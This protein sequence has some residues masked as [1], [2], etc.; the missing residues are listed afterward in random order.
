MWQKA[1]V[2]VRWGSERALKKKNLQC[3]LHPVKF[4]LSFPGGSVV[5]KNKNKNKKPHLPMQETLDQE[6]PM[7][8]EMATHS[9]ILAWRM[10]RTGETGGLPSMGSQK[11]WT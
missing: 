8:K 6:D 9:S 10:P 2:E 11:N 4:R 1:T 5:S 3:N 7:E